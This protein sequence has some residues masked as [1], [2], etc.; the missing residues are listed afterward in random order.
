[1]DLA[2]G[3]QRAT[4]TTVK[5][6]D[7]A[8]QRHAE[9]A[10]EIQR[11]DRLYYQEASPEISDQDYDRLY[12][13]LVD[14][15]ARFPDLSGPDSPT[16]RVGGAPLLEFTSVRHAVPMMSL[17]NTYSETDLREFFRRITERLPGE[18]MTYVIEPKV[19][20]VA[21]SLRYERGH[22][23]TAATR[24]D[25]VTGDDV[26]AN[27]RT[28]RSLPLRIGTSAEVLEFRGEVYMSRAE[29]DRINAQR[30]ADGLPLFANPRNS[31]AGSLKLLDP[32]EVA[33]RR[34]SVVLYGHGEV[35]G[36]NIGSHTELL[37]VFCELGLPGPRQ[38]WQCH[39][40]DEALA[41]IA[42]LDHDRHGFPFD[43]D[44]AVIKVDRFD[45]RQR[46]G[47]TAK[48]PRWA[49][50]YK[51]SAEQAET[52]LRAITL[53]VGRTG[54]LTPVAELAPVKLAGT[55][56]TRATL[57]NFSELARKDIRVG[58]T[59]IV[60][61]AGE[62]IPA[63]IAPVPEKRPPN[64]T[65]YHP[66]DR[67]PICPGGGDLVRE[68]VFLR[69]TNSGCPAQLK[70]RILHFA[71]RN[72]MDIEG[73][74][75]ALVEQLADQGLVRGLPD[76]FALDASRLAALERMGEKSARNLVA[77][78]AASRD[79]GLERLL[80]GLGILH[81]GET[82]ARDIARRFRTIDT[83]QSATA[84]EL[85]SVEGIGEIVAQS[86]RTWFNDSA[87]QAMLR[88][89]AR[90][91]V[92]MEATAPRPQEG[93][94]SLAGMTIVITGTLSKPRDEFEERIR[95]LGGKVASSVSKKTAF[96]LAGDE[97]G[98]KLEKARQLGIPVHSEKAF[99]EL[100][101]GG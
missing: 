31:T 52:I 50:A 101:A 28:I 65:P 60:E 61:K 4:L 69:C 96:V 45:Q 81:V 55:T 27:A 58:D 72:A 26:T 91:G 88:D 59:V 64:T 78:I 21:I 70:R 12:R 74:G 16:R 14:L 86:I 34:L 41:A 22:L 20:G 80:F 17:D 44:G 30:E 57:H 33:K 46:L 98:S 90:A 71:G 97:A 95:A 85:Q 42:K 5:I 13:E 75:E 54:V 84:D 77:A 93:A 1:L 3:P 76:I 6:P 9:L 39:S 82:A 48:A 62:I 36:T 38:V 99:E 29:F 94:S 43:T 89:L 40:P 73:L 23:V 66:P 2:D 24:G 68:D 37:A 87:S 8:R 11:H 83:L 49:I 67:C 63:V 79:R 18:Q 92:S 100:V 53:Q 10:K 47:S 35:R 56:V 32:R 15:E 51:Y 7:E 25:G 19:D